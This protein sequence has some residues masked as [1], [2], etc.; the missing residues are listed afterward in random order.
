MGIWRDRHQPGCRDLPRV[1]GLHDG[2]VV[3]V[4]A[5]VR[6]LPDGTIG[7]AALVL[8]ARRRAGEA[9]PGAVADDETAVQPS[10][11]G[12]QHQGEP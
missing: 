11:T 7:A 6:G 2:A 9:A 3:I 12:R 10:R 1:R 4:M 8:M 5:G